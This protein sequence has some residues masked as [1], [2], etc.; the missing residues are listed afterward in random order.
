MGKEEKDL[1]FTSER[2]RQKQACRVKAMVELINQCTHKNPNQGLQPNMEGNLRE[3]RKG[4]KKKVKVWIERQT[5]RQV[6]EINRLGLEQ[7]SPTKVKSIHS[8]IY[9]IM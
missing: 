4:E 8:S 9:C 1:S 6:R 7:N 2:D 5:D 3:M